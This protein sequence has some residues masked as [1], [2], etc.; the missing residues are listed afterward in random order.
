MLLYRLSKAYL[1]ENLVQN[2][3]KEIINFTNRTVNYFFTGVRFSNYNLH[4]INCTNIYLY[5]CI[6]SLLD[7]IT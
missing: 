5:I 3:K 7:S 4:V 6:H 2:R 1:G